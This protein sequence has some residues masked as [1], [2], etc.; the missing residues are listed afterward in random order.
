MQQ[1]GGLEMLVILAVFGLIF[2]FMIF[3]PQSKRQKEQRELLSNLAK[4]DEI[5]TSGGLIGKIT[6]V[7]ADSENIVI[8]LNDNNEVMISRNFVV[9]T[10]QK[11]TMKALRDQQ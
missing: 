6:K 3:R 4:G 10:L 7:S 1:G 5:L 8:A 11:G 2:Y 9:A